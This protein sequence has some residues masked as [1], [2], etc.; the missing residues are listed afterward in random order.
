MARQIYSQNPVDPAK[1]MNSL[2]ESIE[3]WRE[4]IE[5]LN[6]IASHV[7]QWVGKK[8]NVRL[9]KKLNVDLEPKDYKVS[10]QKRSYSDWND[11][12]LYKK[13]TTPGGGYESVMTVDVGPRNEGFSILDRQGCKRVYELI[14]VR[15][16]CIDK[17]RKQLPLLADQC[18]RWNRGLE[19]LQGV[20]EE[21]SRM[22]FTFYLE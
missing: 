5:I 7:V 6:V 13:R 12:Q 17:A 11:L 20:H 22:G 3:Q 18:E 10:L 19:L 2:E 8:L 4:E 21:T 16:V 9:E 15:E 1:L 14:D